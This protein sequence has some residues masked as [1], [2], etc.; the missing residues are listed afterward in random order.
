VIALYA[1]GF[2]STPFLLRVNRLV[3]A[4]PG[5]EPGPELAAALRSPAPAATALISLV[6]YAAVIA[7]MVLKP[8]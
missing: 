8:F 5:D 3:E 2:S 4:N 1:V 6:L 7:D